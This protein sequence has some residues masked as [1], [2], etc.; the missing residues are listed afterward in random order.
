M[1]NGSQQPRQISHVSVNFLIDCLNEHRVIFLAWNAHL[2]LLPPK[3]PLFGYGTETQW[4][5]SS[6]YVCPQVGS[7]SS[8]VY[9]GFSGANRAKRHALRL[10]YYP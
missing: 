2:E 6:S 7:V 10:Q 1:Q 8:K 5:L 9:G 3:I 4:V